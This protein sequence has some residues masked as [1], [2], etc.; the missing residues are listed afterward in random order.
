MKIEWISLKH[1]RLFHIN[2]DYY[3][4]YLLILENMDMQENIYQVENVHLLDLF[5]ELVRSDALDR[6][7][8]GLDYFDASINRIG[9]YIIGTR[10]TQKCILQA[11]AD[12]IHNTRKAMKEIKVHKDLLAQE[13]KELEKVVADLL[14]A[15]HGSK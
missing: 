6:A 7:H 3:K 9:A 13:K 15:G 5:K 8:V 11:Q 10:A 12:I 1:I 14:N 4:M 2:L